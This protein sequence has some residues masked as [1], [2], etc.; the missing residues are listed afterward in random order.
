MIVAQTKVLPVLRRPM[1]QTYVEDTGYFYRMRA[2]FEVRDSGEQLTFDYVVACNIRL[3]R[4]R[5]GGLSD[6]STYGPRVVFLPTRT[7][8]AIM[9]RTLRACSGLTSE[10]ED[11]P[12]DVLPLAVWFENVNDLSIGIGYASEDA[13]NSPLSKLKFRGARVDHATRSDWEAWRKSSA[14][15][16]KPV[17]DIPGPWGYDF[18]VQ[19]GQFASDRGRYVT[20]CRGYRRLE[21]PEHMR[22]RLAALRPPGN[23]DIWT[24]PTSEERLRIGEVIDDPSEPYP[25]GIGRWSHRFGSLGDS[26]SNGL[27]IKSGRR[28]EPTSYRRGIALKHLAI[29]WPAEIY[30]FLV[31][32]LTSISPVAVAAFPPSDTYSYKIELRA[33]ALKGFCACYNDAK[34]GGHRMRES[35]PEFKTKRH[36]FGAD[37]VPLKELDPAA[38]ELSVPQLLG[39][40]DEAVLIADGVVF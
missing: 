4:W 34:F 8:Q 32:P 14:E 7:G 27:P 18:P 17:G 30:P 23:S 10:N 36:V 28:A 12:P 39:E 21:L 29:R 3:T 11:I 9:L 31:E 16:Y 26:S 5:D 13:Y 2:N 15:I 25:P 24:L 33:G 1:S 40:R 37:D 20:S 6:D 19:R 22:P 38:P 35:D